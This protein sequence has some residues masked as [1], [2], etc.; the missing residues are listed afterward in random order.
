[1]AGCV[2]KSVQ[3]NE[4]VFAAMYDESLF[5]VFTPVI[6]APGNAAK[7]AVYG[8]FHRGDIGITPGGKDKVHGP[9]NHTRCTKVQVNFD[10]LLGAFAV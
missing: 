5:I 2:R 6:L 7:Y 4:A 9:E 10:G 8:A 3:N 1:V